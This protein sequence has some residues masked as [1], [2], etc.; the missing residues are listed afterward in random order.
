[1]KLML[2][3]LPRITEGNPLCLFEAGACGRTVIATSVGVVPEIIEDGVNGFIIDSNLSDLMTLDL[4]TLRLRWCQQHPAEVRVMGHR[5]REK[6]LLTR[7]A[8]VTGQAFR[9]LINRL[10]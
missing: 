10:I 8:S 3:L 7:T 1:M 5:L 4:M 6:I 2:Y 9:S